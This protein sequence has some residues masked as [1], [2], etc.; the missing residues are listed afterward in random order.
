VGRWAAFFAGIKQRVHTIHGFAFHPYQSWFAWLPIYLIELCTSFVT[1]HFVCVAAADVKV[2][3]KLFP[4]FGSKHSII[5]AA[6]DWKHFYQ[7]ARIV[8]NFPENVEPFIFG[9]V[10]CFKQQ[11]NLFDLLTAFA[12]VHEQN[13]ATR[14]ELIGD[15]HLRPAIEAWIVQ[16]NL[17]KVITLHGWQQNVVPYMTRWHAFVLSSLWEGLPCAVVEARLLKLPVLAYNTGGIKEVISDGDN[18]F[19]YGQ[20]DWRSLATGMLDLT[21]NSPLYTKL[22]KHAEYLED[23][24]DQNMSR[25]HAKLYE[26]L[27][28]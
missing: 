17:E 23:F 21:K 26:K 12:H 7:P 15:G 27:L 1:T 24:N 5:R 28:K 9:T 19:L 22:Q 4:H 16:H 18:G 13:S 6:V 2:G 14:L 11:K 10:A 25:H 20:K 8:T 3:M